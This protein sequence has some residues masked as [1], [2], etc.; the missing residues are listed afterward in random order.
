MMRS[1]PSN[2]CN[3]YGQ[4][5]ACRPTVRLNM[6]C[7]LAADHTHVLRAVKCVQHNIPWDAQRDK[8]PYNEQI[9]QKPNYRN[10]TLITPTGGRRACSRRRLRYPALIAVSF[11]F[12]RSLQTN[13]TRR[14]LRRWCSCSTP[15]SHHTRLRYSLRW[16]RGMCSRAQACQ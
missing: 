3:V 6:V 4:L 1:G 14:D 9:L 5:V 12:L 16:V 13:K 15:C 11:K 7:H 2:L 8:R 10:G